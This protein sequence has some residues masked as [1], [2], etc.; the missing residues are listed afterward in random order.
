VVRYLDWIGGLLTGDLGQS[1]YYEEAVS[2]LIAN[3]L[4]VSLFLALCAITIAVLLSIPLGIIAALGENTNVDLGASLIAFSGVSVPNFFW[5]VIFILVFAEYANLLPPSGYVSPTQD[6]VASLQHVLLP[7]FALAFALMAHIMRMT[8]SSLIEELQEG[9]IQLGRSKGLTDTEIVF[10]HAL[11]NAF[12]PVLTVIG[13]QLAY[14]FGG[15]V[16]IEE[17][18]AFPGLGRLL[19][20]AV[21]NRDVPVLQTAVLL[22]AG[23]TMVSNLGVDLMYG[24]LDPRV[25]STEES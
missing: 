8:R 9:Y 24:V 18:F 4:P 16:I 17:V 1:Y 7:A 6:P 10:R 22:F 14:L 13:F 21:L 12:L 5:G 20:G 23:I 3:R 19:F 25:G 2:T 15:V 11:R